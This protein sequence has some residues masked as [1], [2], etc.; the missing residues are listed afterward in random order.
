MIQNLLLRSVSSLRSISSFFFSVNPKSARLLMSFCSSPSHVHAKWIKIILCARMLMNVDLNMPN[1]HNF[2]KIIY[3]R[4]DPSSTW[5]VMTCDPE[6][7]F[8]DMKNSRFYRNAIRLQS[9]ET[10]VNQKSRT[11]WF[12]VMTCRHWFGI[13]EKYSEPEISTSTSKCR[14]W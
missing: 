1:R 6:N 11:R 3:R 5:T 2:S 8:S 13:W 10:L 14:C 12:A 4:G 7:S 9:T